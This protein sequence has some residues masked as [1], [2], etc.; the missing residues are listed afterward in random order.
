MYF[1]FTDEQEEFRS[2]LRRFLTEKSSPAQVRQQ[3][4]TAEGY[5]QSV[6]QQLSTELGL[7]ALAV[8]S[9]FG[10][11]GFGVTEL[12]IAT[13][14][15]GRALLCAPFFSSAVLATTAVIRAA[16]VEQK[17]R[18]LPDLANGARIATLAFAE[19][20]GIWS[21]DD[22]KTVAEPA[23]DGH[24]LYGTKYFVTDGAIADQYVVVARR[25][26]TVGREGLLLLTVEADAEYVACSEMAP[27]D[28]TRKLSKIDFAGARAELLG[29]DQAAE[30]ALEATLDVA[31]MCL[32]HEMVGGAERLLES[33]V[34]YAKLRYQFG[35]PIGSFQSLKHK[36]ADMLMEVEL[37][38]SG[39]YYAA[40]AIDAG[41]PEA[42]AVA[43][44][45]KAFASDAYMQ[46]ALHTV[47]IHGGIGFT[48]EN[49]THLWFKRAKSSEVFLGTASFHRERM[50]RAMQV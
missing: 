46:T 11:A 16:T 34:D 31:A 28:P 40:A 38:K 27:M 6:W 21:A 44:L 8:P 22:V 24:K 13:E 19:K 1:G 20:R 35:R 41:D 23:G 43:S 37:A 26:G 9:E 10:G 36:A 12:A 14:E 7:T 45:A 49:D 29:A 17:H 18:F 5:D 48:W 47:Q 3:M 15:M 39:A 30:A 32:A 25:A 33:A 2:V 50:M 4:E 42:T